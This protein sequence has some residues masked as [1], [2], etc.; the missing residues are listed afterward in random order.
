MA[1]DTCG[2]VMYCILVPCS[3]SFPCICNQLRLRRPRVCQSRCIELDCNIRRAEEEGSIS[4]E[5]NKHT[6]YHNITQ[7]RSHCQPPFAFRA[8]IRALFT[9]AR[10]SSSNAERSC[11]GRLSS[12]R[13]AAAPTSS[14]ESANSTSNSCSTSGC[15]RLRRYELRQCDATYRG[16]WRAV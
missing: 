14:R 3:C 10:I 12:P 15:T 8:S 11:S 7:V 4:T 1:G 9:K 2:F 6:E 5:N 16:V 13:F